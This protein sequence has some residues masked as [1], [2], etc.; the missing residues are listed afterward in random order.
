MRDDEDEARQLE[1]EEV[2][3]V[4]GGIDLP[5]APCGDDGAPTIV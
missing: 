4:T 3:D 5:P 2:E 1:D